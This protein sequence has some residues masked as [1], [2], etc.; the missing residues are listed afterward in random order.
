MRRSAVVAAG[1][2]AALLVVGVVGVAG[3]RKDAT[4][5]PA[6][7]WVSPSGSDEASCRKRAEPCAS[8]DR[9]YRA[10]RPGEVVEIAAGDYPDQEIA[11]DAGNTSSKHV[12]MRPAKGA[13]V[14]VGEL[15][16]G[17]GDGGRGPRHLT[18]RGLHTAFAGR[19]RQRSVAVL[20]GTRDVDLVGID[21]GNFTIWGGADIRVLGGDWGPCAVGPDA[22]CGNVK[23]DAGPEGYP[24]EDVLVEG[25]RIHDF[26]FGPECYAE[27]QDCHF[28]CMYV[29]G[30]RNVTIR[31]S[32]FRD[33]ALFDI[34]VTVSGPDGAAMGHDGL[35]IESNWF[36]TPW[37]ESGPGTSARR[38]AS[39]ITLAWCESSPQPYRVSIR[40]NS[41]QRNTGLVV[42]ESAPCGT[43][44]VSVV[45]NLMGW[46]GCDARWRYAHNV[47]STELRRGRC[48]RTDRIVRGFP[49]RDGR[50][51]KGFD[52]HLRDDWRPAEAFVVEGCARRDVDGQKRP[53][54]RCDAGADERR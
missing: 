30:S 23:I 2:A 3:G 35:T 51:G 33:C 31:G 10:A 25:A 39:A 19:D 42:D 18:I 32:K 49:Y 1:L 28:E 46:D 14:T 44:D 17:S 37:D 21:A 11:R 24:T 26:R 4:Q 27:G 34:F 16:L 45:G 22:P 54:R 5:R 47:F 43:F 29:N 36:D 38:R 20:P 15:V 12:L 41:F 52:F 7:V 40:N 6:S 8:L 9:A 50:S 48:S 13:R 53:A